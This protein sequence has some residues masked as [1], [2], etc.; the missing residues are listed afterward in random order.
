[1]SQDDRTSHIERRWT[2][3]GASYHNVGTTDPYWIETRV[4]GSPLAEGEEVEVGE[5]VDGHGRTAEAI[6]AALA[7]LTDP[8]RADR[9]ARNRAVA[10]LEALDTPTS[11]GS[12]P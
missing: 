11:E 12:N 8:E 10:I 5:L 6:S 3:R 9:A 4:T 7:V 1:M 2:I